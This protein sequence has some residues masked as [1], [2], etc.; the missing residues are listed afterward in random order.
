MRKLI[1]Y[2]EIKDRCTRGKPGAF[3]DGGKNG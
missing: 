2:N 1:Y 3:F